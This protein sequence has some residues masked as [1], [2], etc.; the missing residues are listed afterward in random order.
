MVRVT[1][2]H[3]VWD[4]RQAENACLCAKACWQQL[5]EG[6]KMG[7]FKQVVGTVVVN[8][9]QSSSQALISLPSVRLGV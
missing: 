4:V 5:R 7:A 2:L 6:Q 9:I 8:H 1:V 3:G